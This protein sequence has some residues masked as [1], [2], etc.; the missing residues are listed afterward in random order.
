MDQN[1]NTADQ[2]PKTDDS[3]SDSTKG[4]TFVIEPN[5]LCSLFVMLKSNFEFAAMVVVS[6]IVSMVT[7]V[8]SLDLSHRS[9]VR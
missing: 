4:N 2:P 7:S 9:L 6:C 1:A 3:T 5:N 8:D